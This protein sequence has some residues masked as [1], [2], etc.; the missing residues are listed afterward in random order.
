MGPVS[1]E[2]RAKVPPQPCTWAIDRF[3]AGG[4][5]V[6]AQGDQRRHLLT[7]GGTV[8]AWLVRL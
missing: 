1:S 5:A 6:K 7:A 2:V 4:V 3:E 8:G